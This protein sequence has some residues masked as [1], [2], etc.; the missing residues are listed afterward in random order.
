[1]RLASVEIRNF[2]CI[3]NLVVPLADEVTVLVGA[4]STGKSSVLDALRWFF[5]GGPL[6]LEDVAGEDPDATVSVTATFSGLTDADRDAFGFH[7]VD[8]QVTL[9]RAWSEAGGE[10]L[11][12]RARAF[13]PFEQVR[14]W[15]RASEK[16]AA[17]KAL[18]DTRPALGLPAAR[19]A[20]AVMDA[21]ATW[22]RENPAELEDSTVSA[23][24]LFQST[25]HGKMSGRLD[26]VLVPAVSDPEA[27]TSDTRGTLLRQLLD[28]VGGQSERML[29]RL[30]EVEQELSSQV[31]EIIREEAPAVLAG[32]SAQVTAELARLVPD[33]TVALEARPPVVHV[34]SVGI[35][36]RVA[37]GGLETDV[38]R[39]GHGFQRALLIAL[40]QQLARVQ[41][42]G[43]PPGLFLALEEP[44]LYQHPLQARHFARTLA[45]LT[46]TGEGA[47][48]VGY[49]THSEHFVDPS[50]YERLRR[51][52]K[53]RKGRDWP[54]A[55]VSHAT[56]DRVAARLSGIV[57]PEHIEL[58]VQI[59]LRRQLAE[60]VFSRAVVLVEGHS[61]AGF[62]HGIADREGGL[63]RGGHRRCRLRWKAS[64]SR[65]MGHP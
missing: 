55:H 44:E 20:E 29:E 38:G 33:G 57:H 59:T 41:A 21:M 49:A 3:D 30:Q 63:R 19:S 46:R 5:D 23:A 61:D 45:D 14:Q 56:F 40:V 8:G 47:I 35:D 10:A 65:S 62:L 51:F 28:R 18:R 4:N 58:R 24:H 6:D 13:P 27:E 11:T 17:Y 15:D 34:P 37:D 54:T 48:Q 36:V 12:G 2:R 32:I 50:H 26:Y 7:V 43:D 31:S 64:A 22:E 53:R 16:N 60:A 52:S 9:C 39:Q 42:S 25:R 1:M